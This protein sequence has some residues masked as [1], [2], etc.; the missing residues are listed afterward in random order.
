MGESSSAARA[1]GFFLEGMATRDVEGFE[2]VV[3]SFDTGVVV[4][5]DA[6]FESAFTLG[7]A[8]WLFVAF[9]GGFLRRGRFFLACPD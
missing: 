1:V 4:E 8:V 3:G 5:L 7:P 6:G 2:A 9:L